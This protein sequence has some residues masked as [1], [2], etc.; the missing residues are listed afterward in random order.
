MT[1]RFIGLL[2]VMMLFSACDTP[3]PTATRQATTAPG[4]TTSPTQVISG[5]PVDGEEIARGLNRE[6]VN[7]ADRL[8]AEQVAAAD[9]PA[10]DL[11]ELGVRLAGLPADTPEFDCS[12]AP[13]YNI[14]DETTFEVSNSDTFEQFTVTA[15]LLAREPN[16]Y[17]WVD[18]DWLSLVDRS[19]AEQAAR[20]FDE[21]ILPRN[22]ELFGTEWSPGI[23][24]DP[25]LHVLN[26]SN[27]GAGG[28]FS[29]VDQYTT[30]VRSDS[31]EKEMFYIDIENMGG[32]LALGDNLYLGVL[33]HEYQH[34]IHF[35][36]D[37]N[38]DTWANEGLSELA[39]YLNGY[40][41]G[42]SDFAFSSSPDTQ[43]NFWPSDNTFPHYGASFTFWLYFYDK[44]GEEG[45]SRI[46]ASEHN[47]LE[48]VSA[49]LQEEG[50]RGARCNT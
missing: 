39:S 32:P 31:N 45:I 13:E 18:N 1:H 6:A 20:E 11:R 16:V 19:A 37:R 14:G 33:A 2:I 49:A 38:E 4:S 48:G 24:C 44:F 35:H 23:D 15:T 12:S 34:M 25:R 9:L 8:N 22:R 50:Y 3:T 42:G 27:T 5:T 17:I 29:S 43:L 36:I 46:V 30:L 47:G 40:S 10:G 7:D 41:V 21:K 26:T 28:Y